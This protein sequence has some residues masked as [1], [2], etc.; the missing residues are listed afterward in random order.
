MFDIDRA[1]GITTDD[2]TVQTKFMEA[3][4]SSAGGFF[5]RSEVTMEIDH[6]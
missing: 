3:L 5:Q 1:S 6:H 2:I 4:S